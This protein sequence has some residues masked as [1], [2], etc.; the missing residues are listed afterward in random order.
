M[1]GPTVVR[2]SRLEM[3]KARE[4]EREREGVIEKER[5][6]GDPN[7]RTAKTKA[8]RGISCLGLRHHWHRIKVDGLVRI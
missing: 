4:R 7:K 1:S 5:E 8:C 3:E 6:Q 2:R